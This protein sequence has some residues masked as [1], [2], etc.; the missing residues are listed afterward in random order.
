MTE[1]VLQRLS[2]GRAHGVPLDKAALLNEVVDGFNS[3]RLDHGHRLVLRGQDKRTGH[4]LD[5]QLLGQRGN[6]SRPGY[7]PVTNFRVRG[8]TLIRGVHKSHHECSH[9]VPRRLRASDWYRGRVRFR[10][11]QAYRRTASVIR[12]PDCLTNRTDCGLPFPGPPGLPNTT[13][14]LTS[15]GVSRP[16]WR[17]SR[18]AAQSLKRASA[19]LVSSLPR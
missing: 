5:T 18:M 4:N 8:R 17:G 3:A 13:S 6:L 9:H 12:Q 16:S 14:M 19:W 7:H 1:S 11:V 10:R 15:M 2:Q